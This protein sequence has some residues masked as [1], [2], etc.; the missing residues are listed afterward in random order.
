MKDAPQTIFA[1]DAAK[2]TGA[3]AMTDEERKPGA[4]AITFA[5]VERNMFEADKL[6]LK[7]VEACEGEKAVVVGDV[8]LSLVCLAIVQLEHDGI[9]GIAA[10]AVDNLAGRIDALRDGGRRQ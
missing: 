5:N 9:P 2:P 8:A 1:A 6:L 10:F 3:A 4:H 7:L